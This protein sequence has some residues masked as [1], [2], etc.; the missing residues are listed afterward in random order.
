M[1]KTLSSED[2]VKDLIDYLPSQ[3]CPTIVGFI[4]IP[5]ITRIF[6]P[7]LYGL[8]SLV[9][10]VISIL[11][12]L[13][14]W[15]PMSINRFH[16]IYDKD[17]NIPYFYGNILKLSFISLAVEIV[18]FFV[19]VL[20]LKNSI[21]SELNVLLDIGAVVFVAQA[22]FRLLL[23]VLR[24]KR[25]VRWYSAFDVWRSITSFVLGLILVIAFNLGVKGL[26]WGIVLSIALALPFLWIKTV[27]GLKFLKHKINFGLTKEMALFSFPLVAGNIAAWV[28]NLSHRYILD[29]LSGTHDVGIYSVSYNIAS[30][31]IMA[32]ITMFNVAS[33]PISYIIWEK[34][35]EIKS[36]LYCTDMA[37]YYLMA[38]I[39]AV[40][41]LSVLS[42]P[43]MHFM[44]SHQY[45]EGHRAIPFVAAGFF[46]L[47]F[48]SLYIPGFTY[49]KHTVFIPSAIACAGL[50]NILLNY[51]F[52]P[53]YG[54]MAAAVN[55]LIS[56]AFLSLLMIIG[57]RR[58]FVWDFPFRTLTNSCCASGIMG[59]IA[60]FIGNGLTGKTWI[61]LILAIISGII[62]Y[63][64]LLFLLKEIK[65]NEKEAL[66]RVLSKSMNYLGFEKV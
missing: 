9:I 13:F 27:G 21:S 61:N 8:Y 14:D 48:Q 53:K 2:F 29:Y 66:K 22:L 65:E 47:G 17:K 45:L 28:L 50:S 41:G 5:I 49:Y 39:P 25:E 18:V 3:I 55:T 59:V 62:I 31:T 38:C 16:A 43:I 37:R 15:L 52:V 63:P 34:D 40:V 54:Y 10:P 60:Y 57:S 11:T 20:I 51:L 58:M 44:A 4:S 46:F 7:H 19:F 30:H 56:Y 33:G 36:K 23:S 32:L 12:T 1:E 24:M 35:G 42:A 6:P 64:L 26:L